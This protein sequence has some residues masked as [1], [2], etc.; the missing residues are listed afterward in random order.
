[1]IFNN[2]MHTYY[3][4]AKKICNNYIANNSECK[5]VVINNFFHTMNCIIPMYYL[6]TLIKFYTFGYKA[7]VNIVFSL[8][9]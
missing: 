6:R 2:I 5:R 4:R 9:S 8:L 3:V 7:Y 1:M